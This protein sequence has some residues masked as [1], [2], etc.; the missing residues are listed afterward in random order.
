MA[1]TEAAHT[2]VHPK[3]PD[4]H[5]PHWPVHGALLPPK[6]GNSLTLLAPGMRLVAQEELTLHARQAGFST[7]HSTIV[8]SGGGKRFSVDT[9]RLRLGV[10]APATLTR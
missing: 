5:Q 1:H 7:E 3:H 9:F 2:L 6:A 4:N 10:P 8:M